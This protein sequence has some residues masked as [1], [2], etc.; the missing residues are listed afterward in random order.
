L[1][2]KNPE[3]DQ[4]KFSEKMHT[5]LHQKITRSSHRE[6]SCVLSSYSVEE[7]KKPSIMPYK[8][9]IHDVF[10]DYQKQNKD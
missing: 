2:H 9:T 3:A 10:P 4:V 6:A 7:E 8:K 1:S 5:Q